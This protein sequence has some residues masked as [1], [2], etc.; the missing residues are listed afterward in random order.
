M[1]ACACACVCERDMIYSALLNKGSNN[2]WVIFVLLHLLLEYNY[3]SASV[4]YFS[5]VFLHF[6]ALRT[7][8][9]IIRML[10]GPL[11]ILFGWSVGSC[12]GA[13]RTSVLIVNAIQE[14]LNSGSTKKRSVV[15]EV[16]TKKRWEKFKVVNEWRENY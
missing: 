2:S 4:C 5:I 13:P 10:F 8:V 1:Y 15:K 16:L 14:I 3:F 12:F 6:A 11:Y 9:H 7:I